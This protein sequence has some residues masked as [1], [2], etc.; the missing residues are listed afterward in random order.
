MSLSNHAIADIAFQASHYKLCMIKEYAAYV[1]RPPLGTL[2]INHLEQ[3]RVV[4][5]LGTPFISAGQLQLL[6]QT[7]NPI[8]TELS[9]CCASHQVSI[10][11]ERA[12]LV[13]AGTLGEMSIYSVDAVKRLFKCEIPSGVSCFG[14][15]RITAKA[16]KAPTLAACFIPAK[17]YG[18]LDAPS[19]IRYDVNNPDIRHG[20][21]DFVCCSVSIL[22][23]P[24]LSSLRVVNGLAFGN[25][26]NNRGF[27]DNLAHEVSGISMTDLPDI[28]NPGEIQSLN[29]F[30]IRSFCN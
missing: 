12:P 23:H 28:T 15:H 17:Y 1:C 20:K 11:T 18:I 13:I 8:Y 3:Y 2:V 10:T 22:G 6:R 4:E 27:S 29:C 14:W 25:M 9:R 5:R 16:Q 19:G 26:M 21:G 7:G 30:G 24:I